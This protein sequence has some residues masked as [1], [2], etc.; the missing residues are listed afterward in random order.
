MSKNQKKKNNLT[1]HGQLVDQD[2]IK[3]ASNLQ[4]LVFVMAGVLVLA[5]TLWVLD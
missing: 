3:V 5:G 1:E 2:L 4:D